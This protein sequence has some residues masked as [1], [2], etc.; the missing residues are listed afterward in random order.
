MSSPSKRKS[1]IAGV[2]EAGRGPL[3]GSVV[4]AAVILKPYQKLPGLRDSKKLS[5][6][7][8]EKLYKKITENCISF[9]VG[10]AT[11]KFI[12]RYG[13]TKAVQKANNTAISKLK[14]QP[15]LVLFDGNDK[16]TTHLSHKTIIKGD[17]F[18]REI[19]AASIIAKVTRDR[20]MLK[21][22]K[23]YP[24]YR[25]DKHKGYGTR[26]HNSLLK[27]HKPC[28]IHRKSYTPVAAAAA[29]AKPLIK[30]KT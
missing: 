11:H 29:E 10:E 14:P 5:H 18:I 22:A 12:D 24:K 27:K 7:Q 21:L 25:F 15:S 16:Q 13:L 4:A 1:I 23:K 6:A 26:L 2:D 9:G 20:E 8:R 3:A 17:T 19:M 28:E 30:N